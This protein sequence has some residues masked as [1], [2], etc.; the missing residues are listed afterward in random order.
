MRFLSLRSAEGKKEN[1]N[2]YVCVSVFV[3]SLSRNKKG[4]GW[5]WWG[6]LVPRSLVQVVSQGEKSKTK[7][8][9]ESFWLRLR[10]NSPPHAED[11]TRLG[12][13]EK[14]TSVKCY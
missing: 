9:T 10:F 14:K 5:W 13:E 3:L 12:L 1:I 7:K 11:L 6:S 8:K 2:M 4:E